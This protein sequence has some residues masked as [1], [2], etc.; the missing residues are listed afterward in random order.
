ME[1]KV[2]KEITLEILTE[3][4]NKGHL[5]YF[6]DLDFA[7]LVSWVYRNCGG[8]L[9]IKIIPDVNISAVFDDRIEVYRLED[10]EVPASYDF[11]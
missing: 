4:A 3:K 10:K 6:E 11:K 7:G 2:I 1:K 5:A 9:E 8:C